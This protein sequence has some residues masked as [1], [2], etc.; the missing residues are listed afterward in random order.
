ME[1]PWGSKSWNLCKAKHSVWNRIILRLQFWVVWWCDGAV[2]LWSVEL[3][4]VLGF[5]GLNHVVS[6][7]VNK[8]MMCMSLP[9]SCL[10]LVFDRRNHRYLLVVICQSSLSDIGRLIALWFSAFAHLLT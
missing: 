8:F 4:A 2:P 9:I 10:T 1:Y 7:W 6:R 3:P 5:L